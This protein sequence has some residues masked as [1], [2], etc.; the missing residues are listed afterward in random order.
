MKSNEEIN[1][2]RTDLIKLVDG[3]CE[4]TG[5][6]IIG[7]SLP[8]PV[9]AVVYADCLNWIAGREQTTFEFVLV[10]TNEI[11]ADRAKQSDAIFEAEF[12]N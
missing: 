6:P 10:K 9:L 4:D 8:L 11:N 7:A 1:Q 3:I 5:K 12:L 2:A